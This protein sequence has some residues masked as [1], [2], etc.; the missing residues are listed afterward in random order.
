MTLNNIDTQFA[1][2]RAEIRALLKHVNSN[3]TVGGQA[4]DALQGMIDALDSIQNDSYK[5]SDS[6][7]RYPLDVRDRPLHTDD[8]PTNPNFQSFKALE[9]DEEMRQTDRLC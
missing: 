9:D 3:T 6:F 5:S 7:H 4:S 2:A 1:V 8:E